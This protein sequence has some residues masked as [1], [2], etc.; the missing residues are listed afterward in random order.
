MSDPQAEK[1]IRDTMNDLAA[2]GMP[3]NS[4]TVPEASW[5]RL[6][7]DGASRAD[8]LERIYKEIGDMKQ[9]GELAVPDDPSENW[10]L[11]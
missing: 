11:T 5:K 6:I 7:D 8:A 3:R 4:A 10:Q 2:G 1:A 9:R